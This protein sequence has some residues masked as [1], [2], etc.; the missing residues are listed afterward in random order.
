M[1]MPYSMLERYEKVLETIAQGVRRAT[2]ALEKHKVPYAVAGGIAVASWVA[3]VDPEAVRSTPDVDILIRRNDLE[4]ARVAIDEAVEPTFNRRVHLVFETEKVVLVE[5]PPRSP[6]N[7]AILPLAQ[8]V[9]MKLTS[10][11]LKDR[12]HI[13]DMLGVDLITP[14]IERA[15]PPE[16]MARLQELKDN[17]N[18]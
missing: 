17:P 3:S 4:R 5:N 1:Q 18:G 10:F 15:L 7:Y 11:R 2:A 14:E 12:V 16:L 13:M 8:L 9:I 6:E